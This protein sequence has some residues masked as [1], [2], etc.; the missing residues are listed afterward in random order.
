MQ[1]R[2]KGKNAAQWTPQIVVDDR[3]YAVFG[4]IEFVQLHFALLQALEGLVLLC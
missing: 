4:L 3:E 2:R 1:K